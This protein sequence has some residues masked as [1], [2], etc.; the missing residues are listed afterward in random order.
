MNVVIRTFDDESR[1]ELM[2]F[3]TLDDQIIYSSVHSEPTNAQTFVPLWD[4]TQNIFIGGTTSFSIGRFNGILDEFRLWGINLSN[5]V[6][7]NTAFDPGSEAGDNYKAPTEYLYVQVSLNSI[8][9]NILPTQI[10]NESPYKDK[11]EFDESPSIE[12]LET[13]DI[14]L[15]NIVRYNRSIRQILP[16][17]GS[18]GYVSSKIRIA[19]PP[20][21]LPES[22]S[23]AGVKQLSRTSSVII[24][25]R[26][27]PIERGRNKVVM[28]SS[29]VRIINDT[30]LRAFGSENI[31]GAMGL[32]EK[33]KVL[34]GTLPKLQ[35]YYN[36]YYYVNVDYNKYIR[37]MSGIHSVLRQFVE[38]FIPSKAS[39]LGGI[40]IEPHYLEQSKISFPKNIRVYGAGTRKTRDA[41]SSLTGSAADYGATF[42]LNDTIDL[43]LQ[44][45]TGSYNTAEGR[46]VR[47]LELN[48]SFDTY[49]IQHEDW[50]RAALISESNAP[51]RQVSI[52]LSGEITKSTYNTIDKQHLDWAD[53]F[54]LSQSL[55]TGS[56]KWHEVPTIQ[57]SQA[58][59]PASFQLID[60]KHLTWDQFRIISHSRAPGTASIQYRSAPYGSASSDAG[61]NKIHPTTFIDMGTGQL[62]K[63]GFYAE[64]N[65]RPG[66]EPYNRVYPRKLFDYEINATRDGGVTSLNINSV[67]DI[68]P[69]PDFKEL[70]AYTYFNNLD[71][72]YYFPERILDPKYRNPLNQRWDI[73]EQTFESATTWSYGTRYNVNDVVY[74]KITKEDT[75]VGELTSSAFIGNDYYYVFNTAPLYTSSADGS[76]GYIDD[77]PSYIPPSLDGTNWTRLRF[78]PDI[79]LIPRRVVFDTFRV[80]DPS[81]NNFK[82]TTISVD[83]AIDRP[84]RYIDVARLGNISPSGFIQ[85]EILV[86]N[87]AALF[88]MQVNTE[89]IRVRLYRTKEV[90]SSDFD[91]NFQTVPTGS[92]GVLLD[93]QIVNRN[94]I[95]L[96][97]PIITL[98]ADSIP[99]AGK[100]FYT[101]ENLTTETKVDV[102]LVGYYFAIEIEKRVPIGY[103]RKHYRF[104]RDNSTATKRRN[105]IGC[106][107][108]EGTTIDG[109]PPVQIFLSEG[110]EIIVS[111]TDS[112]DQIITGGGGTLN[113]TG[114]QFGRLRRD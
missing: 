96:T 8:D 21:F 58:Q 103:L 75:Q 20:V 100:I 67:Y 94:V 89:N 85:G 92:H 3:Q 40:V 44:E 53:A 101:I 77:V 104:Y 105:Y 107:N 36:Q 88:A 49:W 99:P 23:A 46:I 34:E 86:Q 72:I 95:Q 50:Q 91:R 81:L 10:R 12:F 6:I 13:S 112:G 37:I 48:E 90:Q 57:I 9:E 42:N 38:Y 82:T 27:T 106:K 7:I 2:V 98:V 70:G 68:P 31:N 110:S 4:A 64:N 59:L 30:I 41:A 26:R 32:P 61:I 51:P 24:S 111:P 78:R 84:D 17:I 109:L 39:L 60:K 83:K 74:Q 73:D 55:H 62:N 22:Y 5:D 97:N 93:L 63:I 52:D 33:Y 1:T 56:H 28:T 54:D 15:D 76:P 65:G 47:P 19:P 113:T 114:N 18:T 16:Q 29:P 80:T 102:N 14:G 11:Q 43:R 79:K 35:N 71:G 45:I 69:F 108:T 66:A 87:I 25:R